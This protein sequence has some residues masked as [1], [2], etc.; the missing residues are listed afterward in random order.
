M[1]E[2]S[3]CAYV[4]PWKLPL[5]LKSKLAG[6]CCV[7]SNDSAFDY[8]TARQ[9]RDINGEGA[10]R[11]LSHQCACAEKLKWIL[12]KQP[13]ILSTH[14]PTLHVFLAS[15]SFL[16]P[17]MHGGIYYIDRHNNIAIIIDSQHTYYYK[18]L[19]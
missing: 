1:H 3:A 17:H 7:R 14:V 12:D 10:H 8:G 19:M 11:A 2:I 5:H 13:E 6:N 15:N 9:L 4:W 16:L 18:V